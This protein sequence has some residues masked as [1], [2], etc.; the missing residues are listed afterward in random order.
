MGLCGFARGMI[1]MVLFEQNER[2]GRAVSIWRRCRWW[3]T[4]EA[5]RTSARLHTRCVNSRHDVCPVKPP[6]IPFP[7]KGQDKMNMLV[8]RSRLRSVRRGHLALM[9]PYYVAHDRTWLF[10]HSRSLRLASGDRDWF[11]C[12]GSA[13]A[14]S[15]PFTVQREQLR[16]M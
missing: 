4:A 12:A 10:S 5:W 13:G 9:T 15:S 11:V 16:S 2:S 3:C 7:A 8:G 14:F 6:K 1:G